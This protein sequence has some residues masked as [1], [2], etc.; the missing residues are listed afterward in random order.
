LPARQLGAAY[1]GQASRPILWCWFE[2]D[3]VNTPKM[4]HFSLLIVMSSLSQLTSGQ[5]TVDTELTNDGCYSGGDYT[6]L[7]KALL[8]GQKRLESQLQQQGGSNS[9]T[10]CEPRKI[11]C[12]DFDTFWAAVSKIM[13]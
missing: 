11:H 4:L 12:F 9:N 8:V 1:K 2:A 10:S 5:S 13:S 7:F 6:P 3:A